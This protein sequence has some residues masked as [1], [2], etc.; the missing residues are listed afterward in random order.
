MSRIMVASAKMRYFKIRDGGDDED[1]DDEWAQGCFRGLE[2][3]V[4]SW[5]M[6][7]E[8]PNAAQAISIALNKKNEVAMKT[9]HLEIMSTLVNLCNPK[10]SK[11]VP[12]EPVRDQLIDLYGAAVDHPDFVHAFR[13]V[14]D[15]GGARSVH[16]HD[17]ETF[18]AVHVNQK[19]RK[20]RME[21]YS[22]VAPYPLEF[23]KIKNACLKWSWRQTPVK[24]WCQ[25]PPSIAH[26]LSTE[27]KVSMHGFLLTLELAMTDLSKLVSTV[28][29]D[30]LKSRT[31]WI[32]E[33][34]INLMSKV[35][36]VPK[37]VEAGKTVKSQEAELCE[38]CALHLA[39]KLVDL[40]KLGTSD[41]Y[42]DG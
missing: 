36:T 34:E 33:V 32:A 17:L 1:D 10:H 20:M 40:A 26:R 24:G 37:K 35:F 18:T 41:L 15:A 21:V 25:L 28:V 29:E 4:L 13:L 6:D 42:N 39:T 11:E 5:K 27:S 14:I 30:D 3:E 23:P 2:W 12:F 38:D 31:K 16:M 7:V 8:E 19:L 22:I 9:G